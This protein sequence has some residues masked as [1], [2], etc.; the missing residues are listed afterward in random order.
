[1]NYRPDIDGLRAIAILLVLIFHSGLF[2]LP[3][4]FIGVDIFF[5]ISGF[6]ITSII[7]HSIENKQFSLTEFYSRRLWRLQP[8]FICLL[9]M[10]GF[11]AM[12]YYLPDDLQLFSK[13][14]RKT[15]IFT[16]NV[17]FK[18]ATNNY[19]APETNQLPLL[20]MWSLSIE[21]Q[22]YL[23]LPLLVYG[24][25]RLIAPRYIGRVVGLMVLVFFALSLYYSQT[26]PAKT[27]YQLASRLFEFCI[28]TWIA[29]TRNPVV[30]N[31][32]LMNWLAAFAFTSIFYIAFS[33]N[34][35][36][37]FPNVHGLVLCFATAILILVGRCEE[38]TWITRLLS[39]KPMVF[40]G[41][42]SYSLYLW[43]WPVFAV[44]RY[45]NVNETPIMI[46]LLLLLVFII[47]YF[48]WR[49]IEKPTRKLHRMKFAYTILLLLITPI[50]MTHM[51]DFLI[52]KHNGYPLRFNEAA[53]VYE[54][55]SHYK[56]AQ[57]PLCLERKSTEVSPHCLLGSEESNAMK[58]FMIGDSYSNQYW[59]LVDT[60]AKNAN[61]NV[62][63]HATVAC[64]ALP[65]VLQMDWFVN[66]KVYEECEQQKQRYYSMI[67]ANHY[68][69]VILG[70]HWNTYLRDKLYYKLE[71]SRSEELSKQRMT[72]ALDEA[73]KQIIASGAKPVLIKSI[74][75][76]N[77][78]NPYNCF[79]EHIKSRTE[80]HAEMCD[81]RYSQAEQL[82]L[83]NLFAAMQKKYKQL[84]VID[85]KLVQCP[86]GLCKVDIDGVPLFRDGDHIND[87]ASYKWGELYLSRFEN[88][89]L[90]SA[91]AM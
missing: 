56:N 70:E 15:T 68:D 69:V 6:L 66:N 42:I 86:E 13:S 5:V 63:S 30:L 4:G 50:L 45:L 10:T 75:L 18:N 78:A 37:G 34:V 91:N 65:G 43:H 72:V 12:I 87:Y 84:A 62:L 32:H 85:P 16:A 89:L 41:L 49:Y 44:S 51:S 33:Q 11:L 64:L 76:S 14:A 29:S 47:S 67:K 61:I 36:V 2:F 90:A 52:H 59:G 39:I 28:G 40:I 58:G 23:I 81:Y 22:C 79:F 3:S 57:R 48:S 83:D 54:V 20:H 55:L 1:M 38:K 74:A 35:R 53:K 17:F 9:V 80:Y 82:W 31:K 46:S 25:H 88:P 77:K 27:Y 73:V 19:F 8:V 21:W 24:M 7:K 60:L 71:D 26:N